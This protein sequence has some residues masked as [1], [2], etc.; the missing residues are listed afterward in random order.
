LNSDVIFVLD[1]EYGHLKLDHTG[2]RAQVEFLDF[3][4]PLLNNCFYLYRNCQNE[5][6]ICVSATVI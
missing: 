4:I 6:N 3:Q 1:S 5:R 2:A